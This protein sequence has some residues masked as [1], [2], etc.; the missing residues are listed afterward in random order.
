MKAMT[1]RFLLAAALLSLCSPAAAQETPC[2]ANDKPCVMKELETIAA[3]IDNKS[4]RDQTYRELAKSYTYEGLEDRAIALIGRIET[5]DTRAMTIRGI[6]F[7][8]A[9]SQWDKTRYAV[10]WAKLDAEA[11][12]IEHLPSQGIA[13]TYIAMAQAFAGDDEAATA[14]ARAMENAALKHKAFGE[15]AEIQAERG[16][17]SA[18]MASIAEIDS[19]AYRNKA[20]RTVA[21]IFT[22]GGKLQEAYDTA[23]KI[24]NPYTKAQALQTLL[25]RG[26][27]EEDEVKTEE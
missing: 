6:G 5:P 9:D 21:K 3:G 2:T 7:A 22:D 16:D 23:M 20:Y 25:N 26:N 17:F 14:T 4:W 1:M 19:S 27:P 18:A 10:L 12:K 13:W 15:S 8:A 11:K 24:D